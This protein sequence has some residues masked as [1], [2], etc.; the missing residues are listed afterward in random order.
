MTT[1]ISHP[2]IGRIYDYVLGGTFNHEADRRAAQA[3][4]EVFPAYPRWARQNRAFL[5]HVGKRW[6]AEGRRRVLDL[7]SG[8]PTQGHFNEHLPGAAI[9]FSD[10]DLLSVAQGQQLLA[11]TPDMAYC[12]ADLRHPEA[13]IA[14]A[15]SFFG[16]ERV[17]G[18]GCIGVVYFL[19]DDAV[20]ALM[21]RLHAFC[22]PGSALALSLPVIPDNPEARA[23]IAT[24]AEH[25]QIEFYSRTPEQLGALIAPWRPLETR[26]LADLLEDPG[27]EVVQPEHPMHRTAM[28]GVFAAH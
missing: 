21:Q 17:L 15:S 25:A 26:P 2:H 12:Q 9:L 8:L 1:D 18:V 19:D 13:L 4:M 11:Y 10:S 27:D 16:A 3:M 5:G 6:A 24:A 23:A 28:F 7:G 22:A 14:E 20:R